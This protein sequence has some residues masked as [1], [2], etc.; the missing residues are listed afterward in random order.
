MDLGL[1]QPALTAQRLAEVGAGDRLL[2]RAAL[3]CRIERGEQRRQ[4]RAVAGLAGQMAAQVG[5]GG[6]VGHFRCHWPAAFITNWPAGVRSISCW[7]ATA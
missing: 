1:R 7:P 3:P 5:D 4:Q 2:R 6:R